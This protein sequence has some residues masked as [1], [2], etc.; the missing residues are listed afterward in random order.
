MAGK[1]EELL[2]TGPNAP[3]VETVLV[4]GAGIAGLCC[5]LAL[6]GPGRRVILLEKDGP[7]PEGG[8]DAAFRDWRRTGVGHLRQSH[9]FLARLRTLFAAHHP[10]LLAELAGS[11]VRELTFD[12]MLTE[13]QRRAYRPAPSDAE[14]TII[15]SRRTTLELVM[16][17]YVERL[18]G[19]EIRP[20]TFVR[21]LLTT[22][23]PEGRLTVRGVRAEGP[24]GAMELDADVVVDAG[25][26]AGGFFEQLEQAGAR[27]PEFSESAGILYYTRHYRLRPGQSE[28]PRIGA[29]PANGD[30]G[31]LKF[32]VF[33]GDDGCFS[34]TLATP[35][36]EFEMRKAVMDPDTFQAITQMLPGLKR[37]TDPERVEA[38]S[39]VFGMGD[40][41][42]RWRDMVVEGEPAALGYFAVGDNLVRTNPL[43]GRGCSFAAVAAWRLRA[44][45]DGTA[46]PLERAR[47]YDAAVRTE[48]RPYFDLMLKQDRAAVRRARAELTPGYAPSFR[49]RLTKSFVEDGVTV[50]MRSDV[51]LLR[52]AMRGFHMLE[53]PEAW[54]KRPANMARVLGYW[55]RGKRLNA[56]AYAPKAGPGRTEM[57]SALKLDPA[58]DL[59]PAG[60]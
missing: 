8:A 4:I 30:L 18:E 51:G 31:Y 35:E 33:P 36:I 53:H 5:G 59:L 16:R 26:K 17:R 49:A 11:G 44:A 14:L 22:R 56:A 10:E 6:S 27:I 9:A 39:K 55:A 25:G 28:P 12:G 37:W 15:T 19:V 38:T 43:Y 1:V 34:I 20:G 29:P 24:D 48:L 47:A 57:M 54:L 13:R 52:E 3:T 58:A 45:L 60:A 42:C 32:G 46:S 41:I 23:D 50:A 7:P 40:L 21:G 2:T